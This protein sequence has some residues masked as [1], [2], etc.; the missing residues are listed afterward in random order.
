MPPRSY[1]IFCL[2]SCWLLCWISAFEFDVGHDVHSEDE[3]IQEW[4]ER[5]VRQHMMQA[6]VQRYVTI[7]AGKNRM[8]FASTDC[9]AK[10]VAANIEAKHWSSIL[11]EDRDRYLLSPCSARRWVVIELCE[12]IYAD[13]IVISNFEYYSSSVKDFQVLGSQQCVRRIACSKRVLLKGTV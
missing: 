2:V 1:L 5:M 4:K 10:V 11:S 3:G 8:N 9:G 13:M 12:E 7:K 6:D